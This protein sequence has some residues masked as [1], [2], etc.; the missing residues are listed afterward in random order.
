VRAL[1]IVLMLTTSVRADA[2]GDAAIQAG[3]ELAAKGQFKEAVAQFKAA[4]AAAPDR[5]EPDCMIALAYRRLERWG[6]AHLFLGRCAQSRLHAPWIDRLVAAID[7]VIAHGGLTQVTFAVTPASAKI[8]LASF[9]PDETFAP[10]PIFLE[11]GKQLVTIT[12]P[13]FASQKLAIE[14][15][16]VG[17]Y[18]VKAELRPVAEPPPPGA[19]PLPPQVERSH[20]AKIGKYVVLTS[21]GIVAVGVAA[22][23]AAALKRSGLTTSPT[24]WV[25]GIGTFHAEEGV[26]IG[27]YALGAI[28]LA[29]G[30]W[31]WRREVAPVVGPHVAGVAWSGRW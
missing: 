2:P 8:E 9:A 22:D 31:L 6:E 1:V 10:Q 18:E 24:A 13:G 7:D 19:A 4:R 29:V 3:T 25:G 14:V 11:P 23:I 30:A 27:G 12:A 15:P 20:P 28:G 17:P 21:A 16:A 26:A 5:P